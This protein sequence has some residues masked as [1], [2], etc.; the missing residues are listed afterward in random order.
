MSGIMNTRSNNQNR[1]RAIQN[2]EVMRGFNF[3]PV[4][5][6]GFHAPSRHPGWAHHDTVGD[7]RYSS[8]PWTFT[9]DGF[10]TAWN[11]ETFKESPNANAIRW[12]TL[13]NFRLDAPARPSS[14][15]AIIDFFKTGSPVTVPVVAPFIP[16][17][18]P[19]PTPSPSSIPD[20]HAD[21]HTNVYSY[22]DADPNHDTTVSA[23][24]GA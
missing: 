8:A 18:T 12:G 11:C 10:H 6:I 21:R 2:L 15:Y 13:Y 7:A 16:D 3:V 19:T 22:C 23:E 1:D 4:D 24:S 9:D 5:N 14:G 17:F 20:T